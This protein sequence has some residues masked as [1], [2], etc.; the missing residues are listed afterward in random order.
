[1]TDDFVLYSFD[2]YRRMPDVLPDKRF[3]IVHDK[4]ILIDSVEFAYYN[5][6]GQI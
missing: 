4:K 3:S 6:E 2:W 5:P 1:M